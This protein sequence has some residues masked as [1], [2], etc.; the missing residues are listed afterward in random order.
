MLVKKVKI[1]KK[2]NASRGFS[3]K[4]KKPR[5]KNLIAGATEN[6]NIP[7]TTPSTNKDP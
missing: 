1:K 2:Q 6:T 4:S 7:I 5:K 3:N